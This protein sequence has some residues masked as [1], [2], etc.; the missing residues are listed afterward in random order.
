MEECSRHRAL[1]SVC[2]NLKTGAVGG[3]QNVN[4]NPME[5]VLH[6][7]VVKS[8][9]AGLLDVGVRWICVTLSSSLGYKRDLQ[10]SNI[11]ISLFA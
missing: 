2:D 4:V 9:Q 6:R 8:D 1:P 5:T 7:V 11:S 3:Y 10:L